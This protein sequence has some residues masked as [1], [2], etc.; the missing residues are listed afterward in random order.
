[1]LIKHGPYGGGETVLEL[2]EG[3]SPLCVWWQLGPEVDGAR[4]EGVLVGVDAPVQLL[5]LQ[6]V[7]TDI[8]LEYM[9]L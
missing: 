8:V 9:I 1:M 4:E 3:C 7:A 2:I 5:Q 6:M